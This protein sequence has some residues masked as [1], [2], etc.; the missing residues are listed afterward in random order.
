[1]RL[2]KVRGMTIKENLGIG[3]LKNLEWDN[4]NLGMRLKEDGIGKGEAVCIW[5]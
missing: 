3:L 2:G 5:E 1:M 4:K